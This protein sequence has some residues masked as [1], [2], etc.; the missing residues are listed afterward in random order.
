MLAQLNHW[1]VYDIVAVAMGD[2]KYMNQDDEATMRAKLTR[3]GDW[4]R[5]VK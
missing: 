4:G 5:P 1:A 3:G 2:L